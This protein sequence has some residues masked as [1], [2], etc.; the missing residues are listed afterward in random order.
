M[1]RA[2]IAGDGESFA[3]VKQERTHVCPAIQ[4]IQ[5]SGV[6]T[7]LTPARQ[8]NH[9][10]REPVSK[11]GKRIRALRGKAL[12][13]VVDFRGPLVLVCWRPGGLREGV[14]C[15]GGSV[16]VREQTAPL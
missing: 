1:S 11:H 6:D 10:Q 14:G 8:D 7:S 12:R 15:A 13:N 3:E 5:V 9:M 16:P 4:M 2:W